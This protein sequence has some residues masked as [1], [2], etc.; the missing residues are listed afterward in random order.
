LH[1]QW[2]KRKIISCKRTEMV[3]I[4]ETGESDKMLM[5]VADFYENEVEESVKPCGSLMEPLMDL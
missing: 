2:K 1:L 3:G 4:G 5:K